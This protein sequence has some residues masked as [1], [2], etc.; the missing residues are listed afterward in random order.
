MELSLLSAP[1][2][3]LLLGVMLR[4]LR[5][6]LITLINIIGCL[7]LSA[8]LMSPI[9]QHWQVSAQSPALMVAVALAMSIDYSL[10]LLTRFNAEVR[11]GRDYRAAVQTMLE[12][13]GHTVL[14][15]GTTLCICFMAML[16]IPVHSIASMGI[17]A[18]FTGAN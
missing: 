8:L 12:T 17:A 10:F 7:M 9:S 5:Q 18:A 4:N 15:S 13:S 11:D 3:F 1:F 2:A 6:L 16:L 14:I